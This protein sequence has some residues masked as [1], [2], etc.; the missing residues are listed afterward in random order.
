MCVHAHEKKKFNVQKSDEPTNP[1][2]FFF[3]SLMYA[4]LYDD[5]M[6]S[7]MPLI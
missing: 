3:H 7:G 2:G 4:E 6:T 1:T 5:K